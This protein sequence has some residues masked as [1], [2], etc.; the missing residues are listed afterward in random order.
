MTILKGYYLLS[1][2]ILSW[3]VKEYHYKECNSKIYFRFVDRI[4]E[5]LDLFNIAPFKARYWRN[6][7]TNYY[8]KK[9]TIVKLLSSL[10]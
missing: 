7:D 9:Q 2:K 4:P 1:Q 5:I 3:I 6:V 8:Y 10:L